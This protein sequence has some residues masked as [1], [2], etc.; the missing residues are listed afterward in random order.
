MRV[1]ITGIAGFAG[2]HLAE[3]LVAAGHEV[4]GTQLPGE[5]LANLASLRDRIELVSCDITRRADV[6]QAVEAANPD[7]IFHLGRPGIGRRLVP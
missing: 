2:S 6:M 1:L 3:H 4:Y 5:N 7:W